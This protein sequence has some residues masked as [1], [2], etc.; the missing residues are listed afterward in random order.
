MSG[1]A[2]DADA[3]IVVPGLRVSELEVGIVNVVAILRGAGG[4]GFGGG[5]V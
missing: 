4:V 1:V 5:R 3:E 2:G